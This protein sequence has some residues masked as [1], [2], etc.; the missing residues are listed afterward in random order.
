MWLYFW[1]LL[2]NH[3]FKGNWREAEGIMVGWAINAGLR[4][5]LILELFLISPDCTFYCSPR[6]QMGTPVVNWREKDS[7][8]G[9]CISPLA[10]YKTVSSLSSLPK[11]HL[12]LAVVSLQEPGNHSN[13]VKTPTLPCVFSRTAE[14]R[15]LNT[16]LLPQISPWHLFTVTTMVLWTSVPITSVLEWGSHF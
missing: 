1:L 2:P 6:F 14:S 13:G 7:D 5:W 9:G 16:D 11:T 4:L 10:P 12:E 15:K 8:F 3:H